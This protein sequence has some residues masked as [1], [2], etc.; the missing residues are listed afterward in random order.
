MR[1]RYTYICVKNCDKL[2]F[3]HSIDDRDGGRAAWPRVPHGGVSVHKH[4]GHA[5][6][7]DAGALRHQGHHVAALALRRCHTAGKSLKWFHK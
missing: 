3:L 4:G 2:H 7:D 5:P 6:I 1:F